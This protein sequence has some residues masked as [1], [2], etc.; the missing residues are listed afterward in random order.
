MRESADKGSVRKKGNNIEISIGDAPLTKYDIM[1]KIAQTHS[2][3]GATVWLNTP[4]EAHEN[5]TPAELMGA[6]ELETVSSLVQ[7]LNKT[8]EVGD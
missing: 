6:G 2:I 5:K 4:L 8:P 1:K 7:K 3:Y